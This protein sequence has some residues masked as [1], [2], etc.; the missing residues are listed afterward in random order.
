LQNVLPF[1]FLANG[2][3]ARLDASCCR[4]LC[5]FSLL[6]PLGL[7]S[8]LNRRS[9]H[10]RRPPSTDVSG[11]KKGLLSRRTVRT[12]GTPHFELFSFFPSL[13][14]FDR[15]GGSL[16]AVNPPILLFNFHMGGGAGLKSDGWSK[17]WPAHTWMTHPD[18]GRPDSQ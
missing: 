7:P 15:L 13:R 6:F 11:P 14:R 18:A 12:L 8:D 10:F 16:P 4:S 5:L 3:A 17:P 2:A 1:D 9:G